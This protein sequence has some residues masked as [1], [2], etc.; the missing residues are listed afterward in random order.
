MRLTGASCPE[1]PTDPARPDEQA[2]PLTDPN[3]DDARVRL[4]VHRI[5]GVSLDFVRRRY[6]VCATGLSPRCGIQ[7]GPAAS[8]TSRRTDL[9]GKRG[10]SGER[11]L[12]LT[13]GTDSGC[14]P[15]RYAIRAAAGRHAGDSA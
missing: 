11:G 12:G 13:H 1:S 15:D 14:A 2:G 10:Q 3:L 5:V 9:R 6:S 4:L 8:H 7:P